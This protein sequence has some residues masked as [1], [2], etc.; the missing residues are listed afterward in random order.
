MYERASHRVQT[1]LLHAMYRRTRV[2]VLAQTVQYKRS[3]RT[4]RGDR[5]E[6]TQAGTHA[7]TTAYPA[8]APSPSGAPSYPT[9][10]YADHYCAVLAT[11]RR[12]ADGRL[13]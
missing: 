8:Q 12:A 9:P 5:D 1:H 6:I 11:T 4:S 2:R 3:A 13:T 10:T 7:P